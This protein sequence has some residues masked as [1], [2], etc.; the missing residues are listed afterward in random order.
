MFLIFIFP[1]KVCSAIL[2]QMILSWSNEQ[3]LLP[4]KTHCIIQIFDNTPAAKD[5]TLESGDEILMVNGN[6]VKVRTKPVNKNIY[7]DR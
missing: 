3:I 2:V 5:G 6:N 7:I 1:A 4:N